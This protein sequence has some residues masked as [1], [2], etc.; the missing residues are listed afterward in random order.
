MAKKR[1]KVKK[2]A[3]TTLRGWVKAKA[4]KIVKDKKGRAIKALIKT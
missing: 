4:V 2:N 1:K 3:G